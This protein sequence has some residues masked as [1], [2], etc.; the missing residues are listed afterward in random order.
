M[1]QG[2]RGCA[3][4]AIAAVL[5]VTA[6]IARLARVQRPVTVPLWT[7]TD[8]R[9]TV[10]QVRV[11]RADL[12]WTVLCRHREVSSAPGQRRPVNI[13]EAPESVRITRPGGRVTV[14]HARDC[15]ATE[16]LE[17]SRARETRPG[18]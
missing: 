4:Q 12:G 10:A 9:V 18:K 11:G 7:S 14:V 5:L 16:I 15:S 2:P 17:R 13:L 3:L 6:T 1:L 8:G